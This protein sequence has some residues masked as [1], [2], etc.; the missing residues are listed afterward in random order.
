M[1]FCSIGVGKFDSLFARRNAFP[2]SDVVLLVA[3]RESL[4]SG[5]VLCQERSQLAVLLSEAL[6]LLE[7]EREH[8]LPRY[9]AQHVEIPALRRPLQRTLQLCFGLVKARTQFLDL[10]PAGLCP[11]KR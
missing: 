3:P 1:D 11:R 6:V 10:L 2:R 4:D 7:D 5:V 8:V 9:L